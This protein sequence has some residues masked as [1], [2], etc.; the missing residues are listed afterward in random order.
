MPA[1]SSNPSCL[2]EKTWLVTSL[3][4]ESGPLRQKLLELGKQTA[5]LFLYADF[6]DF[7]DHLVG[8]AERVQV[9]L[10]RLIPEELPEPLNAF[11]VFALLSASLL[12]DIGLLTSGSEGEHQDSIAARRSTHRR[13]IVRTTVVC[14]VQ[15][16]S[17]SSRI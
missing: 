1:G 5:K 7:T 15:C 3:A 11:E 13:P 10:A 9:I 16:G 17:C 12:H 6:P 14:P 8:H 4:T 2:S